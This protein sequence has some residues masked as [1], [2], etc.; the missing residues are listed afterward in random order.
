[1]RAGALLL[2]ALAGCDLP[3]APPEPVCPLP[4]DDPKIVALGPAHSATFLLKSDGSIWCWGSDTAALCSE[5][6]GAS[7]WPERGSRECIAAIESE[8]GPTVALD[9]FGYGH[10]YTFSDLGEEE[11][12]E[13]E[14]SVLG[15]LKSISGMGSGVAVLTEKGDVFIQ[16]PVPINPNEDLRYDSFTRIEFGAPARA[17]HVIGG[18]C[19]VLVDGEVKCL[20]DNYSGHMGFAE[21][22]FVLEPTT[23]PLP[24]PARSLTTEGATTCALLENGEV[25]CAG[26]NNYGCLGIDESIE[27]RASF[28]RVEGLGP[29]TS[30]TVTLFN[31][32][33]LVEGDVWCWGDNPVEAGSSHVPAQ[34]TAFGDVLTFTQNESVGGLCVL[35]AGDEVWCTGGQLPGCDRPDDY[36]PDVPAW[37][38]ITFDTCWTI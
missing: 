27:S 15:P 26:D 21:P 23:L 32:C 20:G 24:L 2:V 7:S 36:T 6:G 38:A 12:A 10:V 33:A 31:T 8:H 34:V 17:I 30:V 29:A 1:M 3:H 16:G 9:G 28:A 18:I 13:A 11:Q 25:H 22:A 37:T 4:Q 35:R 14:L 19:A 5:G